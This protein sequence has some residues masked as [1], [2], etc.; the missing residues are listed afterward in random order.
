MDQLDKF[1]ATLQSDLRRADEAIAAGK[2]A[3]PGGKEAAERTVEL[4]KQW[5]ADTTAIL[6]HY[7]KLSDRS[8]H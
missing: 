3:S 2:R 6:K 8:R 4:W 1:L 5:K 7:G